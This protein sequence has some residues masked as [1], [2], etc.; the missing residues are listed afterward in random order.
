MKRLTVLSALAALSLLA[1][2]GAPSPEGSSSREEG[3]SSSL[4]EESTSLPSYDLTGVSF[5]GKTFVYDG[6]PHSLSIEG[7]LPEGVTVTYENNG[8]VD[9]G[10]YE[11]IALFSGDA[12]HAPIPAMRAT[13]T[14]SKATYD[15]SGVSFDSKT[16]AYDGEPHSLS[17]E[18][19]LPE[20]VSVTYENNRQ[21]AAGT[22][23]VV[24]HFKGDEKN[25]EA[26]P[27][28]T[29]TLTISKAPIPLEGLSFTGDSFVYD[30]TPKFLKVEG[31]LPEGVTVT[32][33]NNGKVDVGTYEVIAHFEDRSGNYLPV[34]PLKATLT[35]TKATFVP[36][37]EDQT[38]DYDGTPKSIALSNA[39]PRGLEVVYEGNGQSLPGTYAVTASF[40]ENPNFEPI[41]NVS[42]TMTIRYGTYVYVRDDF[43][44]K[45]VSVTY[46]DDGVITYSNPTSGALSGEN[47]NWGESGAFFYE[48]TLGYST[49]A[50]TGCRYLKFDVLFE[51]SVSSFN[52][53]FGSGIGEFYVLEVPFD[54][55]LPNGRQINFFDA[56]GK[57]VDRVTHNVY[58]TMYI[59]IT[60][61]NMNAFWTNGGSSASPAIAKIKNAECV[62]DLPTSVVP[63]FK[64]GAGT[65]EVATEEGKEGAF[66][67][68]KAN[69]SSVVNFLGI[70]HTGSPEV[71]EFTGGFFD[72]DDYRYFIFDYYVDSS[73]SAWYVEAKG[74]G[75][76][77]ALGRY[78]DKTMTAPDAKIY[79][80]GEEVATMQDGWNTCVVDLPHVGGGWTDFDFSIGGDVAYMRNLRYSK[81]GTF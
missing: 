59:E 50:Q 73:N 43:A 58:Y 68:T 24:A 17:I 56:S 75:Y 36:V 76:A 62:K 72:S 6:E 7:T 40:P 74:Q 81:I 41:E 13:L 32:Y 12:S 39:L 42:A 44:S 30:G 19:T 20:G 10:S 57:R 67:L 31:A 71:N 2:C 38:V 8:K 63:Y 45:G 79:V 22:Y 48:T 33:E 69:N 51:D 29:A 52:L 3:T 65:V 1:S 9:A 27:D 49:F 25:H 46:G 61:A 14:I 78:C 4:A 26:I 37:F 70:T 5:P 77:S 80:N 23:E 15:L 21:V 18:G 34:D 47:Q 60:G 66:K 16:F 54:A 28:K 11:V 53:R 55:P 35:I 64:A